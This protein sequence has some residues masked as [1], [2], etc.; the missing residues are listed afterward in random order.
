[1]SIDSSVKSDQGGLVYSH[2]FSLSNPEGLVATFRIWNLGRLN[3]GPH[4]SAASTSLTEPG[5]ISSTHIKS[6]CTPVTPVPRRETGSLKLAGSLAELASSRF[7]PV[8]GRVENDTIPDDSHWVLHEAS[9]LCIR[10]H[11][12]HTLEALV[13]WWNWQLWR[14]PIHQVCISQGPK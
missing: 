4:V 13:C 6:K 12:C 10:I 2:S 11:T 14:G 5:S 7:N 9:C 3:L 8:S 1:M